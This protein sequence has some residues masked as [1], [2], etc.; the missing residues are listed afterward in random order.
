MQ[1]IR[2]RRIFIVK[3]SANSGYTLIEL[4]LVIALLALF[5]TATLSLVVSSS[6]AYKGIVE[7]KDTDSELRIALSYIDTKVKQNDSEN[8]LRLK[9]NPVG[10]G[11][12]LVIEEILDGTSY[13]T[14][15]Y[16][17]AGRLREAWVEKGTAASDDLSFEI[18]SIEG[19]EAE[20]D[21]ESHLL[22][23][24]VWSNTNHGQQKLETDIAVK[25]G[26]TIEG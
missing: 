17:S 26:I 6:T 3:L 20:Y 5:G 23:I 15:V 25:T 21:I 8:V 2:N 7:Q 12:A 13:E 10:A 4:T 22:H 18:A 14:W 16:Y 11:S 9:N 19:F 1:R 24:T